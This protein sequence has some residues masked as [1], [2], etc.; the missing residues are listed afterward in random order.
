MIDKRLGEKPISFE[1]SIG[2][3]GNSMDGQNQS[4]G[5]PPDSDEEQPEE[6]QEQQE[7][8]EPEWHSTTEPVKPTT[9]DK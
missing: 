6:E 1:L 9:R 2:N 4:V 3:Y 7:Q 8:E 5:P